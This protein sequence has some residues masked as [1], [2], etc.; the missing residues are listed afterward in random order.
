MNSEWQATLN[1]CTEVPN[2]YREHGFWVV[3]NTSIDKYQTNDVSPGAWGTP[4]GGASIILGLRP[5]VNL[6]A[7][8]PNATGASY[9][10]S[11]FHTHPPLTYCPPDYVRP[12]GPSD[13]D[14]TADIHDNVAGIVYDFTAAS[15]V[16]GH[17]KNDVAGTH[18]SRAQ[19]SLTAE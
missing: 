2:R 3:L 1:D 7:V 15:I 19:R 12:T 16:S 9:A 6:S 17:S 4:P 14:I 10:V 13:P 11:S 18:V 5:G 8:V